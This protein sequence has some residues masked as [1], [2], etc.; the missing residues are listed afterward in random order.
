MLLSTVHSAVLKGKHVPSHCSEHCNI[1]ILQITFPPSR[2]LSP[3]YGKLETPGEGCA[4]A[5]GAVMTRLEAAFWKRN[6]EQPL[7]TTAAAAPAKTLSNLWQEGN[8]LEA[9]SWSVNGILGHHWCLSS[10]ESKLLPALHAQ[11]VLVL[12]CASVI[13]KICHLDS[14]TNKS[15]TEEILAVSLCAA[16]LQLTPVKREK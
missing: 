2:H 14:V 9:R 3:A 16:S 8:I 1:S 4:F 7:G 10:S 5:F 11:L 15:G 6:M 12:A 13:M